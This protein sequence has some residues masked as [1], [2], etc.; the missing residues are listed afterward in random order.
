MMGLRLSETFREHLAASLVEVC[1]ANTEVDVVALIDGGTIGKMAL[2]HLILWPCQIV[3]NSILVV[4]YCSHSVSGTWAYVVLGIEAALSL[5]ILSHVY[6]RSTRN[7][8]HSFQGVRIRANLNNKNYLKLL[9]LLT[10]ILLASLYG[11]VGIN[12]VPDLLCE[13]SV[14]G[15]GVTRATMTTTAVQLFFFL[16]VVVIRSRWKISNIQSAL[17]HN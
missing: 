6:L 11:L 10:A 14:V 3:V 12:S 7:Y 13:P 1:K 2:S 17:Q 5:A 4:A 9:A 8:D 15:G 16:L